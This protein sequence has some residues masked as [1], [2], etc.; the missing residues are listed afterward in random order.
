MK[1]LDEEFFLFDI[2]DF[3]DRWHPLSEATKE[4]EY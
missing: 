2:G 1:K 3:I 4:G